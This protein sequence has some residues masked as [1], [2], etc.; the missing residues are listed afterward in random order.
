M[1]FMRL[2]ECDSK[3]NIYR[4]GKKGGPLKKYCSHVVLRFADKK[5]FR[6]AGVSQVF[7]ERTVEK[8]TLDKFYTEIDA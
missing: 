2:G 4:K 7:W 1:I 5:A 3:G 8:S 6:E